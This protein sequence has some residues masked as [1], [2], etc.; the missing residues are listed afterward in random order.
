MVWA[1]AW[2][3]S[4][5]ELDLLGRFAGA[6]HGGPPQA[7]GQSS[8]ERRLVEGL[9]HEVVGPGGEGLEAGKRGDVLADQEDRLV[10]AHLLGDGLV[11]GLGEGD[12]A[13]HA[14]PPLR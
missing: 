8:L 12:F 14:R 6:G 2:R 5:A 3:L 7:G 10:A 9:G 4:E 1:P 11:D 13:G